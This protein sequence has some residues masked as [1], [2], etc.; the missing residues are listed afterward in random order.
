M[1]K[2]DIIRLGCGNVLD[3]NE[4]LEKAIWN[5]RYN[6]Y[7]SKRVNNSEHAD[8]ILEQIKNGYDPNEADIFEL[9]CDDEEKI[10]EYRAMFDIRQRVK[11]GQISVKD[12]DYLIEK[13]GI[14]DKDLEETL[15]ENFKL[16][17]KLVE[18]Y[19]SSI[20]KK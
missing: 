1:K 7:S 11:S 3:E 19:D 20:P 14:S 13:I 17:G 4:K 6:Y 16:S 2:Y 12:Y 5:Q 9:L 10:S 18:E 15:R 8:A